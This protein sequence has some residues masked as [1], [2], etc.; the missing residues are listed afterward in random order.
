M[1]AVTSQPSRTKANLIAQLPAMFERLPFRP[2]ETTAHRQRSFEEAG[3]DSSGSV[4]H[5]TTSTLLSQF[6]QALNF[7]HQL[8]Q[9][10]SGVAA[11]VQAKADDSLGNVN[12]A[13]FQRPEGSGS[14]LPAPIQQKMETAFGTSFT[15]VRIHET[16]KAQSIGAAAYTQ[17]NH[18]YF[19]PGQYD[20]SSIGGQSLLGHE[21]TH[22][23]QQRAGRVAAPGSGGVPINADPSLEAEADRLGAQAAHG[24]LTQGGSGLF[25]SGLVAPSTGMAPV[26]CGLF[27]KIGKGIKKVGKGIGKGIKAV[28]KKAIDIAP[29]VYNFGLDVASAIPGIGQ[30]ANGA[31]ALVGTEDSFMS[32]LI[33]GGS[34]SDALG[35]SAG[36]FLGGM[37]V[38]GMGGGG[39]D[40]MSMLG[41]GGGGMNPLSM[42]SGMGGSGGGLGSMLGNLGGGGGLSSM[43]GGMGGMGG[44]MGGMSNNIM[45]AVGS[46]SDLLK[47][48]FD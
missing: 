25:G 43:I 3:A 9:S 39:M 45:D 16:P 37:G 44:G 23:V 19:A 18:I 41:G 33:G 36:S 15:D 7:G 38:P 20:P 35:T 34:F 14:A 30:Y 28:G 5:E 40:A 48:L 11:T 10:S 26:Q 29:S 6:N 22:V 13:D 17:G 27:S 21:L 47:D 24:Q 31:R 4:G 1:P 12:P 46:G 8:G 2:L 42:L 32:S